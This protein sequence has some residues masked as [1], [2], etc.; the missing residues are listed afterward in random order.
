MTNDASALARRFTPHTSRPQTSRLSHQSST[1][2]GSALARPLGPGERKPRPQSARPARPKSA[3]AVRQQTAAPS[4]RPKSAAAARLFAASKQQYDRIKG[5]NST[6][7]STKA[8]QPSIKAWAGE[9][10][11][12][13]S[14]Q[15]APQSLDND[16]LSPMEC[17][18]R[19]TTEAA[20]PAAPVIASSRKSGSREA[21]ARCNGAGF[22]EAG[23]LQASLGAPS[24]QE[25]TVQQQR[26]RQ[27]SAERPKSRAEVNQMIETLA[28]L[29]PETAFRKTVVENKVSKSV[30]Q[31]TFDEANAKL[32]TM[33]AKHASTSS[34]GDPDFAP[35][36]HH[37]RSY[38]RGEMVRSFT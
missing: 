26:Q 22:N 35:P 23:N 17:F 33:R 2:P 25:H 21:T 36:V 32:R 9:K 7:K 19:R 37:R 31:M 38:S 1:R 14:T 6:N 30:P 12:A 8:T 34:S 27:R 16:L 24:L 15:K 10:K 18:R 13:T 5:N 4:S 11:V 29:G 3:G 28:G 20:W